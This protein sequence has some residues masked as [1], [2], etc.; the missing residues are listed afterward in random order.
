MK[1][2]LIVL[3]AVMLAFAM[4]PSFASAASVPAALAAYGAPEA[5]DG[6]WDDAWDAAEVYSTN[7]GCLGVTEVSG[8]WSAMYDDTTLDLI[9]EVNDPTTGTEEQEYSEPGGVYYW[10]RNTV[11]FYFDWGNERCPGI[12]DANDWGCNVNCRGFTYIHQPGFADDCFTVATVVTD[13]GYTIE[14]AVNYEK[15]CT[16]L[17]FVAYDGVAIGFGI[18]ICDADA[19]DWGRK[20]YAYW[21]THIDMHADPQNMG[22]LVFAKRSG[23]TP[24]TNPVDSGKPEDSDVPPEVTDEKPVTDETPATDSGTAARPEDSN[25]PAASDKGTDAPAT[26]GE[27]KTEQTGRNT[28]LIIGVAVAALAVIA[29]ASGIII[30]KKKK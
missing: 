18:V 21:G 30:S 17:D 1:K 25:V 11:Q 29:V 22:T 7:V 27:S 26:T 9:I 16:E 5:V 24:S 6:V 2:F 3:M 13:E 14:M 20:D 19:V 4:V 8:M 10:M 28:G 12:Y 15:A 23:D